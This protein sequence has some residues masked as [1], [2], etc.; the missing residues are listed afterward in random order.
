MVPAPTG[1]S[2]QAPYPARPSPTTTT[3][4]DE[5]SWRHAG[6]SW[7]QAAERTRTNRSW[8]RRPQPEEIRLRRRAAAA[9]DT[10]RA[11]DALAGLGYVVLHDR[12]IVGTGQVLDHVAAGPPGLLLVA[13]HPVTRLARDACGVLHDDGHPFPQELTALRTQAEELLKAIIGHLPGWQLA[14]YPA[15]SL[16]G[17]AA[18]AAWTGEPAALLTPAQLCWW[19]GT[20]PAPLA[21]I[22]VSDLALA[23]TTT[24]Q[25]AAT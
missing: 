10:A 19:A 5:S 12:V 20:L 17:A 9:R 18:W 2:S 15:L 22:H 24:C 7:A 14:C 3:T 6:R 4:F 11:L 8:L 1:V 16:V 21:P 23:L 25:P 13:T